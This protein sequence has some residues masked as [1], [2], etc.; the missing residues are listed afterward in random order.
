MR[1]V[2]PL[3]WYI[4]HLKDTTLFHLTK[5]LKTKIHIFLLSK[6]KAPSYFPFFRIYLFASLHPYLFFF[7]FYIYLY[8]IILRQ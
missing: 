3:R 1:Q 5:P 7:S 2:S 4:S 6:A 8:H